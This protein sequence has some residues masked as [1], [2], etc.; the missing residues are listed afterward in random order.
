MKDCAF[1]GGV[2][3]FKL[4]ILNVKNKVAKVAKKIFEKEYNIRKKVVFLQPH[5][6]RDEHRG[7]A[8]LASA[9]AWGARGR[10]FESFHPDET[11]KKGNDRVIPFFVLG[12]RGQVSVVRIDN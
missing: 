8:Q 3:M 10:K 5:F 7:V 9:L 6:T 12:F 4:N 2:F 11:T 1:L